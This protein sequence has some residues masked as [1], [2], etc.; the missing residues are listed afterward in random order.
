VMVSALD[1]LGLPVATDVVPGQRAD[2]PLYV[3]ALTRVRASL[4]RCGLLYGGD[5]KM[6]AL[7]TRAVL[8]AGGDYYLC[9]LSEIQLPPEVLASYLAPVWTGE[10]AVP[11]IYRPHAGGKPELIADG[12]ERLAPLR[13]EV[14]GE[15]ITWTERRLVI[16]SH[17][18]AQAGERALRA[19]LAKAQ[20]AIAA[21]NER[22][23]GKRRVTERP[24]LQEAV[25]A[26]VARYHVQGWLQVR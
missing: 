10:Q 24:A 13:A 11:P 23:R 9:P 6:G 18:R 8:Q 16:R 19:R 17:Q 21:L 15:P 14:A 7:E 26:I 22:R 12:F 5:G 25:A 3:P 2:D 1:P 4:E 20:V